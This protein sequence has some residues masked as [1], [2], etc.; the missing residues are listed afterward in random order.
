MGQRRRLPSRT[1]IDIGN[2]DDWLCG[3]CR[4]PGQPMTRPAAACAGAGAGAA[5]LSSFSP[6][7]LVAEDVPPGEWLPASYD[8]LAASIDHIVPVSAGGSDDPSNLQIAHLCCNL[9]VTR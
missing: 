8:L 9:M 6:D 2:R 7:E 5:G 4:D 1:V 3:I